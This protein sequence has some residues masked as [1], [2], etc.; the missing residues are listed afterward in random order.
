MNHLE[1]MGLPQRLAGLQQQMDRA[2]HGHR[3]GT[4]GELAKGA[5]VEELHDLVADAVVINAVV[6]QPHDVR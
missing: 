1:L 2:R 5:A 3:A 6:V 4:R